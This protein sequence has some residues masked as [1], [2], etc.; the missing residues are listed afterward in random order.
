MQIETLRPAKDHFVAR[1]SGIRDRD[2]ANALANTKLYVPRERLPELEHVDEFYH[3]DL[4]GL[5]VVD[6]RRE[7]A[8]HRRRDPQFRRR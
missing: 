2:A 8:R 3:A 6:P 5:A 7:R 4:V 1:L